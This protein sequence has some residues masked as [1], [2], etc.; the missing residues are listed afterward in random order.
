MGL[1][2]P[3]IGIWRWRVGLREVGI[4]LAIYGVYFLTRGNLPDR[5]VTAF[6][7]S[8][9]IVDWEKKLGIFVESEFQSLFLRNALFVKLT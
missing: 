3:K 7:N 2:R 5:E 9:Q 6:L 1:G 4:L 8:L